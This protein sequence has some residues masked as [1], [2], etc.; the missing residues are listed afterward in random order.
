MDAPLKGIRVV[1]WTIWQQGPVAGV[2]LADLGAEVIKL[3]ERE[4]GDPARWILAVAGGST[5]KAA[6]NW[7]F[8]ANNRHK[9]SLALDLKKPEALEVVYKLAAKSDVFI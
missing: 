5:Y 4:S 1:D 6:R 7:Y 8:E 2:M 3:E 9:K